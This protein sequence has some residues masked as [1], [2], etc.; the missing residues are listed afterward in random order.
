MKET[1][2][3][4][5]LGEAIAAGEEAGGTTAADAFAE[6]V[7]RYH[8]LVCAVAYGAT[9]NRALS[10]DVAQD[11]FVVAWRG[12]HSLR[13]ASRVR[14]WLCAIAR[15]L[16]LNTHRA[17]QHEEIDDDTAPA[18][19]DLHAHLEDAQQETLVWQAL[20]G[21][22][23]RYRVP[24]VLY[25]R[26]EKSVAEVAQILGITQ[27]NALQRLSRGRR[28]L[29]RGIESLV[30]RT[31]ARG[32]PAPARR[33]AVLAAF[34]GDLVTPSSADAALE[35]ARVSL[36]STSWRVTIMKAAAATCAIAGA[37]TL[38]AW[39]CAGSFEGETTASSPGAVS[40]DDEERGR[41]A[42]GAM[43]DDEVRKQAQRDE[44]ARAMAM[45]G[46]RRGETSRAGDGRLPRYRISIIDSNG[47]AVNLEGGPSALMGANE[48][49]GVDGPTRP[50]A[51]QRTISG[52]V[53]DAEG[54][55]VVGAVVIAGSRLTKVLDASISARAGDETDAQGRYSLRVDADD[56]CAVLALDPTGWST[57]HHLAAGTRDHVLDLAVQPPTRL[58]GQAWRGTTHEAGTVILRDKQGNLHMRYPTDDTGGFDV[59]MPSGTY[60][61][62]FRPGD[63]RAFEDPLVR[64]ILE[65]PAGKVTDWDPRITIGTRL[66]VDLTMPASE[67]ERFRTAHVLVVP[68]T[69]V[70]KD[71]A[72][73]EILVARDDAFELR[74][75]GEQ[76]DEAFEFE[77]LAAGTYTVCIN[78]EGG[79]GE[80]Q[81][82][83]DL[84]I[85]C[86]PLT[87]SG[88]DE[89]Q[90]L[91]MG[92]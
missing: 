43:S 27:A 55:P 91:A 12:R 67:R 86:R 1:G 89:V 76:L 20:A 48:A 53:R 37:V 4:A 23:E 71:E 60:S 59:L 25:Y 21:I 44:L 88:R 82:I 64:T 39:G 45:P 83:A 8:G 66:A 50:R 90:E 74:G 14:A 47:I 13:D 17:R 49:L 72:A 41:V 16:A 75:F 63:Q 84:G 35:A 2:T 31:L 61:V 24:L 38:I 68:G 54:V 79:K 57:V 85:V 9:G 11:T 34:T 30:E 19:V 81:A 18:G 73:R 15:H 33:S 3:D 6:L 70:V 52:R 32:K 46:T 65:L 58:R 10:E 92:W 51:D 77:D 40:E 78:A 62:G 56:D 42:D 87:I 26:E 29:E 22:P 7:T 28:H 36:T 69:H 80:G 5:A